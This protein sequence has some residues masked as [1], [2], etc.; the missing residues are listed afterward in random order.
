VHTTVS[1]NDS[2]FW[3]KFRELVAQWTPGKVYSVLI[4][5]TS[6]EGRTATVLHSINISTVTKLEPLI[7]LVDSAVAKL[8]ESYDCEFLGPTHIRFKDIGEE[9]IPPASKRISPTPAPPQPLTLLLCL[10]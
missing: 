3:T 1:V 8:E 2:L 7:N 6:L 5:P 4:Q 10:H 9:Y